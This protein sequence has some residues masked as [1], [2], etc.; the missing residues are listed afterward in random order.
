MSKYDQKKSKQS[1]EEVNNL[2][3]TWIEVIGPR[4]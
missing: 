3:V 2:K 4:T 1:L